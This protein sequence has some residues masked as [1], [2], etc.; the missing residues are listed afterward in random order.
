[1]PLVSVIVPIYK[2]E[3]YIERCA[4]SLFEQTLGDIEY[5]F[6]DDCTPDCSM[7]ILE[8][9]MEEYPERIKQSR[10]VHHLENR[11]LPSARNSGLA[12]AKGEYIIHCDSDDWVEPEMYEKM[13]NKAKEE[14]ADIV[15]C[16]F[17]YEYTNYQEYC[18]QNFDTSAEM[19]FVNLLKGKDV[20]P[21]TW[22]RLIKRSIY[23]DKEIHFVEGINMCEDLIVNVK[24]HFFVK[25]IVSI[26][27]GYYHYVQYNLSSIVNVV[28]LSQIKQIQAACYVIEEFLRKEN[29]YEQYKIE[30][31]ER[32]FWLK[33]PLLLN[34]KVRNYRLWSSIYPDAN[35]YFKY[36]VMRWDVRWM[37]WF[38]IIGKPEITIFLNSFKNYVKIVAK[39][40]LI[41]RMKFVAVKK[42]LNKML[43]ETSE[44]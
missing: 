34:R 8:R 38:A 35:H 16:D 2:V 36:Y 23:T 9:V 31:L 24:L 27:K 11:G 19:C 32:V 25:K 12:L 41:I 37:Y 13:Y 14:D 3:K 29:I 28:N 40:R 39:Q 4:R 5:I 15:G 30:F 33:Q 17:Y 42:Y 6:V 44:Y 26:H 21:N 10:I 7:E 22:C 1:M 18:W 20:M 43:Y